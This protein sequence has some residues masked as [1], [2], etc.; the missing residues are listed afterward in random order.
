MP[1]TN[2]FLTFCPTDTGTNL[3]TESEYAASADRTSGNKPG[4]ASAKL[5]NK[6]LRQANAIT[7]QFAQMVA[8]QLGSDV[9]DD[10]ISA[11]LLGQF[12]A[13]LKP[14]AP[15][16]TVLT[17]GSGTFALTHIFFIASGSATVGATYTNN[18]QTFTV[19]ATVSGATEIRMTGTGVPAT[20]GTLTKASGTGDATLTFY[21]F[22]KALYLHVRMVGAGAGGGSSANAGGSGN[23]G[24]AGG[25]STF[26]T[27]LLTAAGGAAGSD[28]RTGGTG[29]AVTV[30]SPA[31]DVNSSAGGTGS[32]GTASNTSLDF[33]PVG[34]GGSTPRFTMPT[35]QLFPSGNPGVSAPANSGCGGSGASVASAAGGGASTGAGGGA[36]GYIEATISSPSATYAY[37]VGAGGAGGASVGGGPVGGTGGSGIIIVEEYYQ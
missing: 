13:T 21:A 36:G 12:L 25:D 6:A 32:A 35:S 5:N 28:F 3:L 31:V 18:A 19:L 4:V 26:G 23:A 33:I 20:N 22:R 14:Y 9:I 15:K 27:S 10:G 17:S 1:P 7:S 29:G 37:A 8:N 2:E 16:T 34:A 30:N 24:S 11:R